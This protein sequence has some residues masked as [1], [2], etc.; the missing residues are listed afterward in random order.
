M[1]APKPSLEAEV[2]AAHRAATVTALQVL[3]GCLEEN[4]GLEPGQF[5][6]AL[7]LYMEITKGKEGDVSAMELAMLHEIRAAT[8]D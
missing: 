7:K 2:L 8:L 4:G 1:T 6:E 3:V 5:A